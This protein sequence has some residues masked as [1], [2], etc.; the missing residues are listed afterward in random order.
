MVSKSV[1][2]EGS[3][4]KIDEENVESV[5]YQIVYQYHGTF[6]KLVDAVRYQVQQV[7]GKCGGT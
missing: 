2:Q 7:G 1:T 3:R 6:R 5:R 4:R